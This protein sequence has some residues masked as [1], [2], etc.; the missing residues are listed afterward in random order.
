MEAF[1]VPYRE[2][3]FLDQVEVVRYTLTNIGTY[4]KVLLPPGLW[5]LHFSADGEDCSLLH[6]GMNETT[7]E[8]SL[9]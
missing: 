8:V 9:G 1:P 5:H 4:E 3:L 7:V 2:L 6:T